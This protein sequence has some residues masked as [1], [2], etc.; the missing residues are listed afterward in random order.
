M[1]SL[2]SEIE[3]DLFSE[4]TKEGLARG[5]AQRRLLVRLKGSPGK[6]QLDGKEKESQGLLVKRVSKVSIAKF[7]GVSWPTIDHFIRRRRLR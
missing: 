4:R 6:S 1:F 2:F 7:F 3:R 5:R